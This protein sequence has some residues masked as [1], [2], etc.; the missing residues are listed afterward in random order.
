MTLWLIGYSRCE[1]T[2][3]AL[4]AHGHEVLTCDLLPSDHPR[5]LQCDVWEVLGDRWDAAILHPMC[6]YLTVSAAWAFADPDYDRYPGS[7]YHPAKTMSSLGGGLCRFR[8]AQPLRSA[9]PS[10]SRT[11]TKRTCRRSARR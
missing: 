4:E 2:L 10:A 8:I 5:H 11:G 3:A 6:T 9:R 7:G 1:F